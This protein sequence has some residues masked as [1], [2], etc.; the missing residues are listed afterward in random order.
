MN[1]PPSRLGYKR[2]SSSHQTPG[3]LLLSYRLVS[4]EAFHDPSL[5]VKEH[6]D[7][8]AGLLDTVTSGDAQDLWPGDL[9]DRRYPG[10]AGGTVGATR[11]LDHKPSGR[12]SLQCI[13]SPLRRSS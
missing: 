1:R 3:S 12:Y 5:D 6:G 4:I 9:L 2:H 11:P 7:A 13:R 10:P 8:G